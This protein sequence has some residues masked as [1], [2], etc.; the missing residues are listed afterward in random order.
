MFSVIRDRPN[1]AGNPP[2]LSAALGTGFFV[3]P[4]IFITCHHVMNDS[5]DSHRAGDSYR[6]IAN[7]TGSSPTSHVVT[8]PQVG[9]ELTLFPSL[10]L[11]VLRVD[12]T[13]D[14]PYVALAYDDIRV[15]AEVGVV[16]YPLAS[17]ITD[18]NGN[19]TLQGLI[20]RAAYGPVTGRYDG[21]LPTGETIPVVEVNF[22]FVPGNSG[23]PVFNVNT[24]R[25]C[26]MVQ[27]I[28]WT[29]IAEQVMPTGIVQLPLGV[30]NPYIVPIM[31]IYSWGI[32][33][34]CARTALEGFGVVP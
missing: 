22:M 9:Q 28:R 10:D 26:G 2:V 8:A 19:L 24:G 5:R 4:D 16:G 6:L 14:Q 31:A 13:N 18:A 30:V 7:V 3:R 15:G 29:R 27:S 1:P 25:V 23:G 17:L 21:T 32:K 12:I 34:D 33:L 20:Y 11:A